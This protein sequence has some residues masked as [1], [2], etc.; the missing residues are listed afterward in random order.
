MVGQHHSCEEEKW[1]VVSMREL[2]KF[3]QGL[4]KRSFP[5]ASDR[6]ADGCHRGSSLD[7][8]LGRLLMLPPDTFSLGRLGKNNFCHPYWK[9][10]LQ[11]D[12]FWIEKYKIYLSEDDD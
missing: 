4:P 11:G 7:E 8:L 3:E 1:K 5:H 10:P 9:L 2:H 12:A 6:P